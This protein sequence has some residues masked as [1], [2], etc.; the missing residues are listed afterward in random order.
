MGFSQA[1]MIFMYDALGDHLGFETCDIWKHA[2]AYPLAG[3]MLPKWLEDTVLDSIR[4]IVLAAGGFQG[5]SSKGHAHLITKY[6]TIA[7]IPASPWRLS[8][9]MV[10]FSNVTASMLD[11]LISCR[12]ALPMM[13]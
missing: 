7:I 6:N 2:L 3:I 9:C 12:T 5:T 1:R 10:L 13:R 11:R 8:A 4:G